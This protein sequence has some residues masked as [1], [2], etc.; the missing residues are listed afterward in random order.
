MADLEALGAAVR[1]GDSSE[2]R[3]AIQALAAFDDDRARNILSEALAGAGPLTALAIQALARHGPKA[4]RFAS[5]ATLDPDRRL[6][7]V[8]VLGKLADPACCAQ[9]HPLVDEPD[10]LL[11]LIVAASLYRCGE[12]D[13]EL[14]SSWIRRENDIAVFAFL[15]AIAGSGIALTYGTLDHLEAQANNADSPVEVRAGAAWAVAQHDVTR[16]RAL[17]NTLLSDPAT[18][19]ALSS[20]VR[21]RGG[22]L[23][24]MVSDVPGDPAMDQT[25]DSVGLVYSAAP[26]AGETGRRPAG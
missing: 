18:A 12:R 17:A 5:A 7:G 6:G 14:W 19:F 3:V 26:G 22:P 16:G 21:R 25:A 4:Q 11:R 23:A 9:L 10:P 24:V 8:A 15:A 13:T 2:A 1:A 20:I